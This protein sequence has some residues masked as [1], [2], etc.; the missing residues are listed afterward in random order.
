M[1]RKRKWS[2][3]LRYSISGFSTHSM[4]IYNQNKIILFLFYVF[5]RV[6][7]T[8]TLFLKLNKPPVQIIQVFG[9]WKMLLYGLWTCFKRLPFL[10]HNSNSLAHSPATRNSFFVSSVKYTELRLGFSSHLFLCVCAD[11]N[12]FRRV[13]FKGYISQWNLDYKS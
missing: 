9:L 11:S 12:C 5:E 4:V 13:W 3:L 10:W 8:S 2:V 6:F 7:S 1:G